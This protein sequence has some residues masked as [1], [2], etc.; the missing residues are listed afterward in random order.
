MVHRLVEK[1]ILTGKKETMTREEME[2]MCEHCSA[3][4]QAAAQAE[5]DS[6]KQYQA[7]WMSDHVGEVLTGYISGVMDFGLFV[8]LDASRCEGL[9]HISKIGDIDRYRLGDAVTVKVIKVD[10]N[11]GQIDFEF[12]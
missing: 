5:R 10:E 11:R 6:V 9:I 12:A 3:C 1:Y 4:E 2:L 7:M 8:Q